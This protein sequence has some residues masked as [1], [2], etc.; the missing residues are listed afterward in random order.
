M[1]SGSANDLRR[2]FGLHPRTV[3]RVSEGAD[4]SERVATQIAG[5]DRR[6]PGA[7]QDPVLV[8]DRAGH[9]RHLRQTIRPQ[10]SQDGVVMVAQELQ[11][12]LWAHVAQSVR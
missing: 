6:L 11:S 10:R 12:L 3:E 2:S 1:A 8:V 9:R 4:R 5:L 7:D